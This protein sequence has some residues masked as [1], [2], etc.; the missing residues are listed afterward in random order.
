[1]EESSQT[2]NPTD[3]SIGTTPTPGSTVQD[4]GVL[5]TEQTPTPVPPAPPS[6]D[7]ED[8]ADAKRRN[9]S[10][11]WDHFTK[12]KNPDG[13]QLAKP[14]AKCNYCPQT[15]ACHSK[16]NGTTA[17]R[18]HMLYQCKKS[19]LY[20]PAKKQRYLTFDS[21]EN[22]GHIVAIAYD[23]DECRFACARMIIRDE[24]PF[25]HV[26]GQ[27]FI[28]FMRV[29]QPKFNPPSR[30]TIARDVLILYKSE[31]G[32][33][34]DFLA[35]NEQRVSLTTDT[36]TSIQNINYMVLTAHFIDDSWTLHKRILNFVV[37][38]DHKGN[39][40]GKLV[41]SCLINWGIE[42]VFTIVVD[43]ASPNQVALDYM[44]EKLGN[45]GQLI[46]NG[47]FLHLRCCCHIL[48]LI[49]RDGMEELGS[50]I[51]GIRN[52]VKFIRSSPARLEKFR[53]C[54]AKE[55]IEYK[56][57]IVPLDVCTRWNSTYFM[58]D[59]A[60]KFKKA[61]V[62]L[63]DE[64]QQFENYFEERVS[65]KKRDGPPS[66]EDWD[67]AARLVKFLKIFYDA[68]LQFSG[69]KVVT[70]NQPLLWMC[71]IVGELEKCTSSSD[72]LM[73][74]IGT[75]MKIKFDKY[76]LKLQDMNKILLIAVV[77]DPRYK[78]LYLDFFFPKL[79][80]DN[81]SVSV[82]VDEVKEMFMMLYFEYTESDPV[83][84]QAS[85]AATNPKVENL[86]GEVVD[87][88]SHAAN[89][90]QFMMLRKEKDVVEIKNENE[91][92]EEM[93]SEAAEEM[94]SEAAKEMGSVEAAKEMDSVE[95]AAN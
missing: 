28:D 13:S 48:N 87:E 2:P 74:S 54:A 33:I 57:S 77:L 3:S 23:K 24:L 72:P 22:G 62:R 45:W 67:K 20:V 18:T 6:V 46:L 85:F 8:L 43:N 68:T 25:S 71:T 42:K 35:R 11:A 49:V 26:E 91:A 64:D 83:A 27:G 52:C 59:I 78:L 21:Q 17:M 10:L 56:G 69:T 61:F 14:R 65:G 32:R 79:V 36:W 66:N 53:K 38:P 41:E 5:V 60:M 30:R 76:W 90:K 80:K 55:K 4:S 47:S 29:A 1:M 63:L 7:A 44:R 82:M 19:P 88:D 34:K 93:G 37:I 58:L 12:M 16:A 81:S 51:D 50:S 9:Q 75:S 95:A 70:A 15:Y 84:A 73:V 86:S 31:K 92:A 94:G 40:I 39:T 89:M